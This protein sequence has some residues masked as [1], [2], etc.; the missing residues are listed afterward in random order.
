MTYQTATLA[1]KPQVS[2][3]A[4]RFES[5][6]DMNRLFK[7]TEIDR[8]E[9]LTFLSMRPVHT[10]VMTSFINDNG[11]E[12]TLNRGRFYGYRNRQGKLTGVALIGHS[13][14]VEARTPEALKAFAYAAR[15]PETPI[16]LIM[17]AGDDA[18]TFWRHY[19]GR[20]RQPRLTCTELLFELA[21][22][23]FVQKCTWDVRHA[24]MEELEQIAEAHGEVAF[25][26]SGINP[27]L[28]DREG[29][30]K[31]V[32]RR[33]EQ[34]RIFVVF[35]G[36]KLVFKADIIAET[37]DAAYLEGVFV[38]DEYRGRGVGSSCLASLGLS[39]LERVG[40]VSL[41][42]NVSL[43]GAHKSFARAGYKNTDQCTTLFL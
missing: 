4:P 29:F 22:P 10:V 19:A 32:A 37:S 1:I 35:D 6:P 16:N 25:I 13:T 26:E 12:S 17:S 43:T 31:R 40:H 11:M 27:M 7:L 33:I 21:L 5:T 18:L 23:M 8:E 42:S 30:L 24:R 14:L 15:T 34:K 20:L 41:L 28:T 2:S 9:T 3:P 36:N 39:L 38:G